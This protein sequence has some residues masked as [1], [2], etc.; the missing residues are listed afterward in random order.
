VHRLGRPSDADSRRI[1]ALIYLYL[2]PGKLLQRLDR[3]A[4]LAYHPA[5]ESTN[6]AVSTFTHLP[7]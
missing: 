7:F 2:R 1:A 5:L 3:L 6:T 4:I